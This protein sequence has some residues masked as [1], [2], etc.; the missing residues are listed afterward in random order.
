[1]PLPGTGADHVYTNNG[2]A[3]LIDLLDGDVR[4]VLDVG[5]GAGDNAVLLRARFPDCQ[6]HGLTL[7]AA[8]SAIAASR[9]NSC[10]VWDIESGIPDAFRFR[11]FDAILFS[12]VLEHLHNPDLVLADFSRLLK[13]GGSALVAVPNVVTWSM[14]WRILRGEFQ[15]QSEGILDSTHL[16]F[17]TY[18]TADRY[19]LRRCEGL[20]LVAKHVTGTVPQWWLRRHILPASGSQLVDRLGCRLWPNLFGDQILLKAVYTPASD[21]A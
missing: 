4:Q 5:C 19:L 3:P 16:R 2:N 21:S 12:H 10:T 18:H 15:Y 13:R 1:M 11:T 14:R 8:E 9:M 17:F 20:R 6:I 7:S